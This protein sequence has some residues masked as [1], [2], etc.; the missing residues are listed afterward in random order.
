MKMITL[1][2][3]LSWSS[4]FLSLG[5]VT[6][7]ARNCYCWHAT[8]NRFFC[9]E[10]IVSLTVPCFVV[11]LMGWGDFS[12]VHL[13]PAGYCKGCNV[14]YMVK[15]IGRWCSGR[16]IPSVTPPKSTV[17]LFAGVDGEAIAT[18][19]NIV[20]QCNRVYVCNWFLNISN[21]FKFAHA[22]SDCE[23]IFAFF[24]L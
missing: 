17:P 7:H 19:F 5:E 9:F 16:H 11:Y 22:F 10:G 14:H 4:L 12:C 15:V 20:N 13:A 3:I 6:K 24:V 2:Y 21:L 18:S 23:N 1:L 8:C